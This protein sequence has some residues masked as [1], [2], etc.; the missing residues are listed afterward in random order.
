MRK[1]S[2]RRRTTTKTPFYLSEHFWRSF[3]GPRRPAASTIDCSGA[4]RRIGSCQSGQSHQLCKRSPTTMASASP[5][6]ATARA[7]SEPPAHDSA[8]CGSCDGFPWLVCLFSV[9]F[10][11]MSI[12]GD[13]CDSHMHLH[14]P[15]KQNPFHRVPAIVPPL[16]QEA[17]WFNFES[18]HHRKW[19]GLSLYIP[20]MGPAGGEHKGQKNVAR[21]RSAL[22]LNCRSARKIHAGRS[23]LG[24]SRY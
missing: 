9:R 16:G 23:R 24:L 13:L 3:H 19:G 6:T 2:R 7:G 1:L 22:P 4:C 14:V 8:S 10:R 15:A 20:I 5:R 18:D 11:T 12:E 17:G 21:V